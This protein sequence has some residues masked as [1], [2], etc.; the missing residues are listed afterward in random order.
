MTLDEAHTFYVLNYGPPAKSLGGYS[1]GEDELL[2]WLVAQSEEL[3]KA[4]TPYRPDDGT[5]LANAA[6]NALLL[7]KP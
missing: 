7:H 5:A 4:A 2:H 3:R 6:W 1:K